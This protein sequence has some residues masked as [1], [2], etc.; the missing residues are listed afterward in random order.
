TDIDTVVSKTK[1]SVMPQRGAGQISTN[2]TI[3]SW[4]P[5][6]T[7][8]DDLWALGF[9]SKEAY[10]PCNPNTSVRVAYQT[11]VKVKFADTSEH[12]FIP[13][14]FED[15]LIYENYQLFKKLKG[16]GNIK[17]IR[18]ILKNEDEERIRKEVYKLIYG[19]V[20]KNGQRKKG[21]LDK[22]E[23]AL[24]LL[25][26]K[27]PKAIEPPHYIEEALKWLQDILVANESCDFLSGDDT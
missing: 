8:A 18:N 13:T 24:E 22:A 20:T 10:Y 15:A 21:L 16:L 27:D 25:F 2:E 14:T 5:Q 4:L 6:K 12:E 3:N 23:F 11:P 26:S 17:R 1:K 9:D 7:L 19:T